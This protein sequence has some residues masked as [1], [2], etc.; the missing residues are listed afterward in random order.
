M[1]ACT[2]MFSMFFLT[3]S[4]L[5]WKSVK[6]SEANSADPDQMPHNVASD[7]DLHCLITGLSI[8]NRIKATK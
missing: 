3:H 8:R 6:G 2:F 1:R 4:N 5:E 7:Q